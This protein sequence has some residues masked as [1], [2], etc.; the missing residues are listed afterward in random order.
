MDKSKNIDLQDDRLH[1]VSQLAEDWKS[2]W[3]GQVH[4]KGTIV[5]V[6]AACNYGK[7]EVSVPMPSAPA[8]FINVGK[9]MYK[10]AI[11]LRDAIFENIDCRKKGHMSFNGW[12]GR[13]TDYYE[14]MSGAYIFSV[15]AIESYVNEKIPDD[16][17]YTKTRGDMKC[18]ESYNKE[19]IER[20]LSLDEKV[21]HILPT[22]LNVKSPKGKK[23]Y[24]NYVA[25]REVRDRI[26]HMK[27]KD[28]KSGEKKTIW[29]DL[30][31]IN[32]TNPVTSAIELLKYFRQDNNLPRWLSKL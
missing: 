19:Q 21:S 26:I 7:V 4:E 18:T 28:R 17:V 8:M 11:Q 1:A 29:N 30:L 25:I 12:D 16:Y 27:S 15:T 6:V 24:Q 14:L 23:I 9:E 2:P 5:T 13:V 31:H 3:T 20:F 22:I 32:H 10:K